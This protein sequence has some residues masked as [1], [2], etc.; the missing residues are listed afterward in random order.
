MALYARARRG[1]AVMVEARQVTFHT[2]E[3]ID[4]RPPDR[5][6]LAIHCSAGAYIRSLAYDLGRS[7]GTLA[8]LDVLRRDAVGSFRLADAVTLEQLAMA[9]E[10]GALP[11]LL[12][13]PGDGLPLPQVQLPAELRQRLAHGQHVPL[14]H[15][16]CPIDC[17]ASQPF[18]QVRDEIGNLTGIMRCFQPPDDPSDPA[19]AALWKAEKWLS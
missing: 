16:D 6:L 14:T 2:I 17:T 12:R 8:T 4:F 15:A 19:S 9:A 13:K 7:L 3:L 11:N 18:V 1:E 5:L 10:H